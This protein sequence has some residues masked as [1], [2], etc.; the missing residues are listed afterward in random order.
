MPVIATVGVGL[1][2]AIFSL[3]S[4]TFVKGAAITLVLASVVVFAEYLLKR[5]H[6]RQQA[7]WRLYSFV[8]LNASDL[9]DAITKEPR[10]F[11]ELQCVIADIQKKWSPL[12]RSYESLIGQ[13]KGVCGFPSKTP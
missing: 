6:A 3:G 9:A 7:L 1:V 4:G 2:A 11:D 13:F 10:K 8:V 12:E 5:I